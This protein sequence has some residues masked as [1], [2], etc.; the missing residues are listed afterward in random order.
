[1]WTHT[2]RVPSSDSDHAPLRPPG[3]EAVITAPDSRLTRNRPVE[4]PSPVGQK[5]V[6]P[7]ADQMGAVNCRSTSSRSTRVG[8]PS[9][10][11]RYSLSCCV[12]LDAVAFD[13]NAMV[14]PSGDQ[15]GEVSLPPFSWRSRR[16]P[17]ATSTTQTSLCHVSLAVGLGRVSKA[18]CRE[19]GDQSGLR[20][21]KSPSV[22]RRV[23]DVSR[24]C[25]QRWV[26]R[27]DSSTTSAS[28]SSLRRFSSSS[29]SGSRAVNRRAEPSGANENDPTDSSCSVTRHASPPSAC[30][31]CTCVFASASSPRAA[32]NATILPSGDHAGALALFGPRVSWRL[33]VPSTRT[34][35]T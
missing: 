26:I 29:G 12:L 28:P 18:T 32:R 24:S 23:S 33:P 10:S 14:R 13:A 17:L 21:V 11:A 5:T 15:R 35:Q 1:M 27:N 25:S 34:R 31:K 7:F 4:V 9:M 19:S 30:R 20:T 8:P 2:H 22:R 16:S 3:A 6:L